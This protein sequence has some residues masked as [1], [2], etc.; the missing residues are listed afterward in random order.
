MRQIGKH[1][2]SAVEELAEAIL[3]AIPEIGPDALGLIDSPRWPRDLDCSTVAITFRDGEVRRRE[4]DSELR[5]II[6]QKEPGASGLAVRI[7]MFPTP[8][9]EYFMGQLAAGSCKPHLR[10]LGIEMFGEPSGEELCS[11]G[12]FT[13]FMIAG[14]ATYRALERLGVECFE[15]YPDLQFRLWNG[16]AGLPSKIKGA[17][18]AALGA[19]QEWVTRIA[20]RLGIETGEVA[21]LDEAD[22]AILGLS[23]A[24]QG[25]GLGERVIIAHRAEGQFL[26]IVPSQLLSARDDWKL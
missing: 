6:G 9:L 11:G 13:R 15:S 8:K 5:R 4:I 23:V 25:A 22:A 7:S 19:R 1:R 12:T 3:S 24:A 26:I 10:A 18:S 16:G 20:Q 14:F 2:S 17:R 21:T